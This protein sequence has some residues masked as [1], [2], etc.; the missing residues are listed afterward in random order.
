VDSFLRLFPEEFLHRDPATALPATVAIAPVVDIVDG[1]AVLNRNQASKQPDWTHDDHDSGEWPADRRET[2][3]TPVATAGIGRPVETSG[4]LHRD[5]D[6]DDPGALDP[7]RRTSWWC[8][9]IPT[10]PT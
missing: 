2:V 1:R 5:D 8:S 7:A 4:D 6:W 3:E 9:V 10:R